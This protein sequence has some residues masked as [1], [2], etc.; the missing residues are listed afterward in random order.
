M[1][2]GALVT[3]VAFVLVVRYLIK[4]SEKFR[5]GLVSKP[6]SEFHI[7]V[8]KSGTFKVYNYLK[9]PIRLEVDGGVLLKVEP[10]DYVTVPDAVVATNFIKG[11]VFKIVIEVSPQN[12]R[13]LMNYQLDVP[14]GETVKCLHIG[15]ITGKWMGASED[16]NIGKNGAVAVQGMPFVHFHNWTDYVLRLNENI[17]IS[18]NGVLKYTGR[19][20]MSVRLGTV[21]R[22]VDGIFPDFIIKTPITDLY[23]GVVSDLVQ[24]EFGGFQ[25]TPEF[26]SDGTEPQFLLEKGWMGGPSRSTIKYGYLPYLG[27]EVVPKD[28]WGIPLGHPQSFAREIEEDPQVWTTA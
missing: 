4:T 25:L 12:E 28:R 15:M 3:L 10:R 7:D 14:E 16:Y 27:P 20:H 21:L 2:L 9:K 1:L 8:P 6:S 24:A 18:P 23:F 26:E 5:V 11:N 22:D 19:D 13:V 17:N